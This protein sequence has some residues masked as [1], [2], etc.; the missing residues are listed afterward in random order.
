MPVAGEITQLLER[1]SAGERAA[2]DELTPLV[3]DELRRLAA[4]YLR[5]HRAGDSLQPTLLVHEAWLRLVDQET[6]DWQGRA[7]F[8]G[9][10][11]TIMRGL[12][13]DHARERQAAKRGGPARDDEPLSL[14]VAELVGDELK[15]DLL[16]LDEALQRLA[17]LK[18]RHV[19][20]VELRFFGGLTIEE[21]AAALG[22]ATAT[23]QREWTFAKAWLRHELSK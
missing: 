4:S 23:V 18:P 13:V 9:L 7:Q 16:A 3:Y 15:L 17:R 12:L 22:I 10:A 14:S 5:R 1:W 21:T 19:R 6:S 20:V 2:L 11:A 8:F